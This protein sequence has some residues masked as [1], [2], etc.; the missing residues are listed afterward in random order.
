MLSIPA[1]VVGAHFF[2]RYNKHKRLTSRDILWLF[3]ALVTIVVISALAFYVRSETGIAIVLASY[4]ASLGWIYTNYAN[5]N[6]QRKAHTM[7]VLVQLRNSTEFN[8]HRGLVLA[9]FPFGRPV[10]TND[11]QEL[12]AERAQGASYV[13]NKVPILDSVYYIVNYFEFMSVGVMNGDL[14]DTMIEHTYRSIFVNWFRH[15]QPIIYDAQV[16]QNGDRNERI[17]K[18]YIALVKHYDSLPK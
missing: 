11:L 18:G 3:I 2:N 10:T 5:A 14:D 7:N 8:K 17:F 1:A 12:K 6:I 13:R 15:L 9:K 16:E 4:F